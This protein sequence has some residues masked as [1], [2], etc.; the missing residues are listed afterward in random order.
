MTLGVVLNIGEGNLTYSWEVADQFSHVNFYIVPQEND[1]PWNWKESVTANKRANTIFLEK[2]QY[3]ISWKNENKYN[4]I[5]HYKIEFLENPENKTENSYFINILLF[6]IGIILFLSISTFT[7]IFIRKMYRKY[8]NRYYEKKY[9]NLEK[10]FIE[11]SIIPTTIN[12]G[13]DSISKYNK[14][15]NEQLSHLPHLDSKRK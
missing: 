15:R 10:E 13:D 4:V 2:G 7:I 8:R 12:A 11:K 6:I 9:L 5:L 1:I 14:W 3:T